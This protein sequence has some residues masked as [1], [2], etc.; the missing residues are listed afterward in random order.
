MLLTFAR[1]LFQAAFESRAMFQK[2]GDLPTSR[3][4]SS[5]DPGILA[6]AHTFLPHIQRPVQAGLEPYKGASWTEETK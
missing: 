1:W 4:W 2:G 3:L 5:D 6:L